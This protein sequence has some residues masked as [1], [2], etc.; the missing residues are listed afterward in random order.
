MAQ[1]PG[2]RRDGTRIKRP[3]AAAL[4]RPKKVHLIHGGSGRSLLRDP[5]DR[6]TKVHRI[7][8]QRVAEL[9]DVSSYALARMVEQ[10]ARLSL[11]VDTAWAAVNREVVVRNG[12]ATGAVEAYRRLA[13]EERAVL[14]LL[15]LERREKEIPDLQTY[16]AQKAKEKAAAKGRLRLKDHSDVADAEEVE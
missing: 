10:A 7:L 12:E 3:D 2:Y 9:R 15:D 11:L 14:A 1:K 4:A 13:S 5:L 6:R 8:V 16:L